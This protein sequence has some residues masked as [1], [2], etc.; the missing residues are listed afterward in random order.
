MNVPAQEFV[1]LSEPSRS[2][3]SQRTAGLYPLEVLMSGAHQERVL[4]WYAIHAHARQEVRAE[5]NL[6]A[7][8]VETFLPRYLSRR[9]QGFRV[10]PVCTVKP[11][12]SGYLFAR[13]DAEAM[14]HN[15][16]YTRGVH[17]IV[18]LG[19]QPTPV[20]DAVISM[21]MSRRGE[22]GFVRLGGEIN[23]GDD[24]VVRDGTF[25]GFEGVFERRMKDSE[26]VMILLK[27]VAHQFRVVLP[28]VSVVKRAS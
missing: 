16:R 20:D 18:S 13:F 28:D 21:I 5:N 24:V 2:N 15:I 27:T 10:E 14:F 12:F 9:C 6:L 3:Y 8:N 26:R 23:P 7:W 19:G 17:S 1:M 11:L 22:D 4:H 25:S